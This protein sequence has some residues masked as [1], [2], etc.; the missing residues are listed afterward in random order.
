[1]VV[2]T[3]RDRGTKRPKNTLCGF[4]ASKKLGDKKAT[5][6]QIKR[7]NEMKAWWAGFKLLIRKGAEERAPISNPY[8]I[9]KDKRS[10]CFAI[11]A[12][13]ASQQVYAAAGK[14][15]E[16][17]SYKL[18]FSL[19]ES[20]Q[21]ALRHGVLYDSL[22]EIFSL[23]YEKKFSKAYFEIQDKLEECKKHLGTPHY[24]Y[25]RILEDFQFRQ[26]RLFAEANKLH[27]W[28]PKEG[29]PAEDEPPWADY[30]PGLE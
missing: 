26:M 11:Y 6:A 18:F 13:W 29:D 9:E 22:P 16:S 7:A 8:E 24:G 5:S 4:P 28:A 17:E 19:M 3:Q 27:V 12:V 1:M 20:I 15:G 25:S 30:V 2:E 14:R 23:E 21:N 10:F